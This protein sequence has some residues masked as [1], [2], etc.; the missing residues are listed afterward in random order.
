[1][2]EADSVQTRVRPACPEDRDVIADF[3]I[4]LA[5]ESESLHLDPAIVRNGV[6][7]ALSDPALGRYFV[8][9][10]NGTVVGQT[11]ITYEWSDWRN[12]WFW[13][14]QSVYVHPDYRRHGIFRAL[15]HFIAERARQAGDVCGLRLYVEQHNKRAMQTYE[16][17]GMRATGYVLYESA[18]LD[19]SPSD[20]SRMSGSDSA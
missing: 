12:G 7:R 2:N 14:I 9:E 3:N 6:E 8:A 11:Q 10:A 19:V 20:H 15:Y 4:R 17:L 5:R 18:R 13:W 16:R 1:M